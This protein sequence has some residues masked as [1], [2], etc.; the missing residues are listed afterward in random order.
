MENNKYLP[1]K[2]LHLLL[3]A[4]GIAMYAVWLIF[5]NE[6]AAVIKNIVFVLNIG[7][8][9]S[10]FIYL[11]KGYKKNAQLNYKIFLWFLLASEIMEY[12]SIFNEGVQ[13]SVFR[14][15]VT[16]LTLVAFVMLIGAKDY[17]KIKTN[18]VSITLV[19]LTLYTAI[20]T[21]PTIE[22]LGFFN[23]YMIDALGQ[24]ILASSAALMVCGKYLDKTERGTN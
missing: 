14:A 3:I 4:A 21:A 17:G 16:A 15:F 10:S 2:I 11:S 9:V 24:L 18:I 5:F 1:L 12:T 6:G 20:A 22:S 8:L 19:V 7:A 13:F 23:P